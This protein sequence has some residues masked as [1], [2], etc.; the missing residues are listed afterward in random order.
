LGEDICKLYFLSVAISEEFQLPVAQESE[1]FHQFIKGL[2]FVTDV[3]SGT[4]NMECDVMIHLEQ[5][6]LQY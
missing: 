3:K 4:N 2:A 1:G 5:N 6:L